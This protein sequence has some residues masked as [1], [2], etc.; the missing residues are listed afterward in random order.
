MLLRNSD[1]VRQKCMVSA[2]RWIVMQFLDGDTL[3]DYVKNYL[4][5]SD[6]TLRPSAKRKQ[7]L[8]RVQ[9]DLDLASLDIIHKLFN[10]ISIALEECASRH[11]HHLDLSPDNSKHHMNTTG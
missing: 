7:K 4:H 2:D 1:G 8:I 6:R 5:A 10:R 3:T 9:T 11:F